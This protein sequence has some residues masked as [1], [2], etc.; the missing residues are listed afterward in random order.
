MA[1]FLR[2]VGCILTAAPLVFAEAAASVSTDST[3]VAQP[4]AVPAQPAE[5]PAAQAVEQPPAQPEAEAS[6]PEEP[7]LVNN[8]V[9]RTMLAG[10]VSGFLKAENSPYLITETI[11][12]PE[13]KALVVEAGVVMEFNSGTGL[14]VQGGSLAIVGE[15]QKPVSMQAAPGFASWNGISITGPHSASLQNVDISNAEIGV[16][17][18][19]GMLEMKNV[20]VEYSKSVGLYAR[21]AS[22]DLQWSAF[23]FN[24]GVAVWAAADAYVT[25]EATRLFNNR[26]GVLAGE[27][28][29][30]SM[31]TS[32]IAHNDFGFVDMENNKVRQLRSQIEQNKVGLLVNDMPSDDLKK[33]TQQNMMN[34]AQGVGAVVATL[35]EEPRNPYAEIFRAGTPKKENF[36]GENE[37][38]KSGKVGATVGYHHV[39]AHDKNVFQV[40]GLFSEL[41]AYLLFESRDG[42]SLEFSANL[43]GDDWN[44]FDPQ[45]VLAVYTDKMQRLAVGDVYLSAGETYLSG[46]NVLGGSYDLNLFHNAARDPLFVVSVFGGESQEPKLVGERN[47]DV[48]KDYI[49][50]GE[51]EPQKLMVGGKLRWNMHRRFNGT[52]GFIGSKDYLEDPLLRDGGGRSDMNTSSPMQSSKTFF[53]DGNWLV[54]PGDI[55][56]NGQVALGAADTANASLQRAINEVFVTAGLDASNLAKLR[57]L[58]NNPTLVDI[59]TEAELEEFFGDNSMLSRT[60]MQA[61]L[62]KLLSQAKSLKNG[63]EKK[64]DDPAEFKNWDG[65]NF[66]FMGSM[67]WDLGNTIL[68]GHLRFVGAN[69]YS[70]GSPDLLQNSREA[71]G[72]LDQKFFDFWKLNFNYKIDV[73]NAAHGE[74]YNICGLAEGSTVGLIP[75][76]ESSWLEEHEQDENRTLYDHTA[77][78]NN[79]FKVTKFMELSVGYNMNYRTRSTNQRL[80]AD[81]MAASGVYEDPW[82]SARKGKATVDVINGEDTLKVD[83]ARWAAYYAL[84]DEEYLATQ[85]EERIVK[86]TANLEFKFNLPRNVLKVGGVWTVRRDL[87][88]FEQDDLLTDFDFED[89]TFGILGYY[90]HGGDYFEQRYPVSLTTVV[91][92]FRN[93]LSVV[94]RYKVYNRDNMDDFE[95][96]L[97]DNMTIPLSKNF[98]DLLLEGSFRQEFMN[99]DEDGQRLEESE[100]DVSGSGTLRFTHTDNLTS[101]WTVG[102]YCAYRPDYKV[103][104]YKDI[105]G[106]LTVNYAF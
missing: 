82:F 27:N 39:M 100:L 59:M 76:A 85:F 77:N 87:S 30:V 49:E 68:S 18:E 14:D 13:G 6:T 91:G 67:R 88:R 31:Q 97:S 7:Q 23:R 92:G 60:E 71:Y 56:L 11:V 102:A 62:K 29:Q 36:S 96:I 69:F 55:Q 90:F 89:E 61:K 70:A 79:T 64:G 101:E 98:V 40:P 99:R 38:T 51:A 75:G 24:S 10:E 2:L 44:H 16:A 37:W 5:Q 50:D 45:N 42:R 3:N 4:E 33:V 95:W 78:L 80:Y 84:S 73:E 94:P 25:M 81:Y 28:S 15:L 65:Q 47:L 54:F 32:K 41:N 105:Y 58:M 1:N 20:S 86:H 93:M 26:V 74:D 66:A 17:V 34:L 57:R 52:L 12:V 72:N 53:A 9:A 63:Y 8:L 19:N 43:T 106:M 83:S 103:D 21:G 48:Y 35:R 46:L 22:V 104:Q